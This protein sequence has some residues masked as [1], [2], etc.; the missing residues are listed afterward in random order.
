MQKKHVKLKIISYDDMKQHQPE[1][2]KRINSTSSIITDLKIYP[3]SRQRQLR[4][5][6]VE[7]PLFVK[8]IPDMIPLI[9]EIYNNSK[10]LET[11]G[12]E[13]PGI[14]NE[15]LLLNLMIEEIQS[16]N[17]IEGVKSTRSEIN[18]AFETKEKVRFTGIVHLYHSM[19]KNE[20]L[21]I[22]ELKDFRKIYDEL[23]YDEIE[24]CD[25]P[26]G[27]LFRTEPVYIEKGNIKYHQGDSNEE[28][29]SKNLQKLIK[30]MNL[31]DMSYLFKS[32]ITHYFFEYV[33]P[34][35]DGNGRM[36]RFLLSRYLSRKIDVYTGMSFSQGVSMNKA[37]YEKSFSEVS[38]PRNHGELTFFVI[39]MMKII[40]DGQEKIIK[41]MKLL[42]KQLDNANSYIQDF[43]WSKEK[44][45]ILYLFFQH[46][47]YNAFESGITNMSLYETL[48]Y[49]GYSRYIIDN[50]TE[51]LE[52]DGFIRKVGK[53][54]IKYILS[55]EVAA[56][57]E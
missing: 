24:E 53:R 7:Y 8:V 40:I 14:A 27:K 21:E 45:E 11:I 1:Y 22:S 33:H 38:H 17:E 36:G 51:D 5:L 34:F 39:D 30:F 57:F 32:I 47:F 50:I 25:A 44:S 42:K 55:E 52:R 41:E 46:S 18:K 2:L 37:T 56:L 10:V 9:E 4:V 20:K 35:Y 43:K 13:L 29:I 49:K 15:K 12:S 16:T 31:S 28:T 19:I 26:D 3:F 48:S 6:D 54:P 23:V